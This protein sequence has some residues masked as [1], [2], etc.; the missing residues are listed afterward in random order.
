M[1][2]ER[3]HSIG[4]S[5]VGA[6]LGTNNWQT[7][8][9]VWDR[10]TKN[11]PEQDPDEEGFH[12][13]RGRHLE[14]PVLRLWYHVTGY[15]SAGNGRIIHPE[16]P[17]HY[18]PDDIYTDGRGPSFKIAETKVPAPWTFRKYKED[19][20]DPSYY[21][22]IQHGMYCGGLEEGRFVILNSELAW[23]LLL[24]SEE[25]RK[26]SIRDLLEDGLMQPVVKRDEE[27]LGEAVPKLLEWWERH[28]VGN[29]R[30][31]EEMVRSPLFVA[32]RIG[33]EMEDWSDKQDFNDAVRTLKAAREE[34][35]LAEFAKEA[36][37]NKVKTMMGDAQKVKSALGTISFAEGTKKDFNYKRLL[38]EHPEFVSYYE[39]KATRT[40]RPSLK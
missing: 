27:W 23:I 17:F 37:E 13:I 11:A 38:E 9:Q 20:I 14:A 1:A 29:V 18:T 12:T 28:I 3:L 19:G 26:P 34:Y 21:A 10:I 2:Y 7:P 15:E 5:D 25:W 24:P 36:A 35:K 31:S 16:H 40:F 6:I 32:P 4:G 8:S 30:P 22:Q 33:A 39:Q